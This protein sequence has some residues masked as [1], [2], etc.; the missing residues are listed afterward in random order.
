MSVFSIYAKTSNDGTIW[1]YG[2]SFPTVK[3]ASSG[4]GFNSNANTLY[5]LT[6]WEYT[7]WQDHY[8]VARA[9]MSFDLADRKSV[10]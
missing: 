4:Q 7:D 5:V 9:L 2:T 3:G 1:N 6:G 10:V 8:E